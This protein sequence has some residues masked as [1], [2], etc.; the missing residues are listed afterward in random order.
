MHIGEYEL[1]SPLLNAGGVVKTVEDVR[2]MSQTGVGAIL[3][4]SITLEP[5]AGNG[6][7]G[8]LV[9]YHDTETGTTYNSIGMPNPGLRAITEVLPEMIQIAHDHGKPFILN[10]APVTSSPVAEVI[11]AFEI[12]ERQGLALDGFELNASCP[13]V[14]VDG[15]RRHDILSAHHGLFTTVL[16]EISDIA[17]NE[18]PIGTV[19]ARIAPF[20]DVDEEHRLVKAVDGYV[21]VIAAFNTFPGGRP[22][23]PDGRD[24]LDVP[25][26]LGGQS[27]RG[28]TGLA[29]AQTA[30]LMAARDAQ[31]AAFEVIGSNGIV[32]A[33][34]MKRRLA[35]GVGAVGATTLFW[36]ARSWGAAV[37]GLLQAYAD[38]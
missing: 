1:E 25:N 29:E 32:D 12:L 24:R 31:T 10:F 22:K 35:L 16:G 34:T 9:Y 3:V 33:K 2:Q 30:R 38:L 37:T 20:R 18:V 21:D 4:G 15:G 14:V 17:A 6:P 28:M 13:N 19:I 5:R 8:E 11:D 23:R 27:G 36:E 26:G 7:N